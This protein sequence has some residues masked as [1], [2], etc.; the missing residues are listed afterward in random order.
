MD[1]FSR[2]VYR[3]ILIK[4][5]EYC[6]KNKGLVVYGY[7]IMTNH[8]HLILRSTVGNLSDTVHDF[9]SFTSHRILKE[10]EHHPQESRKDW[11]KIVF[12]Y[13]AKFNKR[14]TNQQ[15]WTHH[16]HAVEL[17]NAEMIDS[18]LKYIHENPVR[19]GWVEQAQDYIYS[20]ARN[21]ADLP[22]LLPIEKL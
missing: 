12:Q 17:I 11:M 9:K 1:I 8:L 21:Y 16:N 14:V 6:I 2:R 18:R 3:D 19:A 15:L 7:V 5:L 4:S 13:H 22:S 10:I 20:S